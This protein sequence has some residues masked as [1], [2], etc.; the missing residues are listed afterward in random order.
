MSGLTRNTAA[1]HSTSATATNGRVRPNDAASTMSSGSGAS[2]QAA[3]GTTSTSVRGCR[4]D[5]CANQVTPSSTMSHWS[6]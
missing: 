4:G 2:S 6:Q 1:H 3:G 5:T